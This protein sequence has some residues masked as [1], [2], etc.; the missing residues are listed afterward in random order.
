MYLH[1]I[2]RQIQKLRHFL[3][4]LPLDDQLRDLSFPFAE[5]IDLRNLLH[6]LLFA[7]QIPSDLRVGLIFLT[8][9]PDKKIIQDIKDQPHDNVDLLIITDKV[10]TRARIDDA[11]CR[12]DAQQYSKEIIMQ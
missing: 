6:L 10:V 9:P 8:G 11:R 4:I 7:E 2:R 5:A 3:V 1:R 12:N